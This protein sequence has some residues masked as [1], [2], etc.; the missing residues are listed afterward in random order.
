MQPLNT[1]EKLLPSI[2]IHAP[3]RDHGT[4]FGYSDLSLPDAPIHAA[5]PLNASVTVANIGEVAGDEVVQL[6][7]K[8]PDVPGAPFRALR[9]F[10]RVQLQPGESRKV[11]FELKDRQLSMVTDAGDPIIPEGKYSVTIGGGQPNTVAPVATGSF[12][13]IGSVRLPE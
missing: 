3:E 10:Q 13:V 12:Q 4:S 5:D 11:S 7:L 6:Y 9:G 8:F 2:S 1:M